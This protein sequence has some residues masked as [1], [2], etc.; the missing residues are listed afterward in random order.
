MSISTHIP[1]P[2]VRG[3]IRTLTLIGTA[4]LLLP[5]FSMVSLLTT[6]AGSAGL[7][8][9]WLAVAWLA[10][11]APNLVYW[12][13]LS[14]RHSADE[15]ISTPPPVPS[16]LP[17]GD[18][19]R[20]LTEA[21]MSIPSLPATEPT[22]HQ[23]RL[24]RQLA[25]LDER[26]HAVYDKRPRASAQAVHD[27]Q[28]QT[29]L[30]PAI[31]R[32]LCA[33]LGAVVTFG[34]IAIPGFTDELG[35]HVPFSMMNELS[36]SLA[37]GIPVG[38][39]SWPIT[40]LVRRFALRHHRADT[41]LGDQLV[42]TSYTAHGLVGGNLITDGVESFDWA[43]LWGIAGEIRTAELIDEALSASS[44]VDVFHSVPRP[45]TDHADIDHVVV[46]AGHVIM[47]DSKAWKPSRYTRVDAGSVR[48][49]DGELRSSTMAEAAETFSRYI[50]VSL[51]S[52]TL[53]HPTSTRN[54]MLVI[55]GFQPGR[56]ATTHHF[57]SA[58]VVI[59]H[60]M[61]TRLQVELDD[62]RIARHR[63]VCAR[64]RMHMA[65]S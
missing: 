14:S 60:L 21:G 58:P 17:S 36:I 50:G 44:C 6:P 4:L 25:E 39:L 46:I 19:A 33:L 7:L 47:L 1:P 16:R 54:D 34:V 51:E 48:D 30:E 20:H 23:G 5:L 8:L 42:P 27:A 65:S 12:M 22:A 64:M 38:L 52:L 35:H 43:A 41:G 61:H 13:Q 11:A 53:I 55:G 31:A 26:E 15:D 62:E 24:S 3:L 40:L 45:W 59:E 28:I 2:A 10:S 63:R 56:P 29:S 37:L 57:A 32:A 18:D 49:T 9:V